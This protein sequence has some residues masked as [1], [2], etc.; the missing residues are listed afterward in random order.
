[1]NK[2]SG[3]YSIVTDS[4]SF[5]FSN[6]SRNSVCKIGPDGKFHKNIIIIE[7]PLS[8][9]IGGLRLF[10]QSPQFIHVYEIVNDIPVKKKSIR[11]ESSEI[12]P[13]I[14]C[15]PYDNL[16]YI[17]NYTKG[18]I[19]TMNCSGVFTTIVNGV[20][21]ISGLCIASRILYFSNVINNTISFYTNNTV[22]TYLSIP[23]PR[24]LCNSPDGLCIC[25]GSNKN[26]GIALHKLGT[27]RYT[28]IF[29]LYLIGNIPLT[30]VSDGKSIYYTLSNMN[31]I[32]KNDKIYGS[33]EFIDISFNNTGITQ[34]VVT[35]NVR[36]LTNP[37]FSA[38]I[39][40][41]T[42]GSNPSNPI[43]PITTLVGRTQGS[44]VKIAPE[45]GISYEELKMR[46]KAEVLEYKSTETSHIGA[47]TKKQ[48]FSNLANNGGSY[49]YSKAR[50]NKLIKESN[51][52]IG[53]D[54]GSPLVKTPPTNSG[55][56]DP[57]FEGYYLNPYIPYYPSL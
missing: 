43:I 6:T 2:D 21:G 8:L 39:A 41:R 18:T 23:N 25:Y 1:M 34:S 3:F 22:Q 5:Y 26:Y 31:V 15:N 14:V 20:V 12:Y 19:T 4:I 33:T 46:R 56:V 47:F 55:I 45:L 29:K 35:R 54:N 49:Y 53:V 24:G 28:N 50:I 10:V 17:S 44:Q 13:S 30:V 36:C 7:M 37:A 11:F 40:L 32:Y 57:H 42:Y 9:A 52:K 16:L 48:N 51:C 27:E 38:L